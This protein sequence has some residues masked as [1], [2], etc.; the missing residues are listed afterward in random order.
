M[1]DRE[2][3]VMAVEEVLME[4]APSAGKAV[5]AVMRERLIVAHSLIKEGSTQ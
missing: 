1:L 4:F 5:N 3:L 2:N